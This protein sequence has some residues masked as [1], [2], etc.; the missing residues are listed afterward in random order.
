MDTSRLLMTL[1]IGTRIH[2]LTKSGAIVSGQPSGFQNGTVSFDAAMV[3]A[4]GESHY[5]GELSLSQDA[6]EAI[7]LDRPK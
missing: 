5:A 2:I 3:N 1:P 4:Q 7:W 6:V